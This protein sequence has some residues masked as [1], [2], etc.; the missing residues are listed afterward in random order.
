MSLP[1]YPFFILLSAF[2][3]AAF[4][5]WSFPS[6][7]RPNQVLVFPEPRP[8][9]AF[10]MGPSFSEKNLVGHWT[11]LFFGFTHCSDI[12]PTT[13]RELKEVTQSLRTQYPELQVVFVSIDPEH[14]LAT[15]LR[16]YVRAFDSHFT[17]LRG[18][19]AETQQLQNQFGILVERNPEVAGEINHSNSLFLI[20]PQGQWTAVFP[21]GL[22]AQE[23]QEHFQTIAESVRH[24]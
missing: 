22:K 18:S 6:T 1:R 2:F 7:A 5:Y 16:H 4:L 14:D 12:C 15:T 19:N 3:L 24:V 21:Y 17:G 9:T 10:Q 8:L 13:L 20:N 11:F 23:I